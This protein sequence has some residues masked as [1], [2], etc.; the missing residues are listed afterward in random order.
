M[1]CQKVFNNVISN[2]EYDDVP[3][4][5]ISEGGKTVIEINCDDRIMKLT[6]DTAEK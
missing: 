6:V 4:N 3:Y 1:T 2:L 5:V